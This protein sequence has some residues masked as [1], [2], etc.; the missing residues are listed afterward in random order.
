MSNNKQSSLELFAITL[1][2]KGLL[3]G[4]GDWMQDIL[5]EFKAMHKSEIMDARTNGRWS[6]TEKY[7]EIRTNIQY[8]NETYLEAPK[9]ILET[10]TTNTAKGYWVE[11]LKIKGGNNEQ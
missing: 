2:E 10:T 1:Y 4:N 5:N 11:Q 8:Y 9:V 3:I 7:G 6:C